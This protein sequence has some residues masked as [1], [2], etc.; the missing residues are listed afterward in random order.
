VGDRDE[1]DDRGL[2]ARLA[3]GDAAAWSEFV[4]RDG[5]LVL[6]LVRRAL[7]GRG[8]RASGA[9]VDDIV[10]DV[11]AA[12]L[13]RDRHLVRSF[14]WGCSWRSWLA[15]VAQGRIG[16]WLRG[17]AKARAMPLED[18]LVADDSKDEPDRRASASDQAERLRRAVEKLPERD[19]IALRL[20]YEEKLS[21]EEIGRVLGA[22]PEHVGVI[23]DR[24]RRKL[25]DMVS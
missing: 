23:L 6:A 7:H 15:I 18:V 11:F 8:I 22:T 9:D 17:R 19:R 4:A 25:R 20:F 14:R 13:E 5:P 10:S 3:E 12:F 2:V 24:A 1:T 21:R 16:R